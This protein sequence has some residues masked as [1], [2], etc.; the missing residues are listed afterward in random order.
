MQNLSHPLAHYKSLRLSP[1]LARCPSCG[2]LVKRHETKTRYFW[3]ANLFETTLIH[4]QFGYYICPLCPKGEKAFSVIPPLFRTPCQYDR[5]TQALIINLMSVTTNRAAIELIRNWFHLPDLHE[6]TIQRWYVKQATELRE[7]QLHR[8]KLLKDFS[9]QLTIDEMYDDGWCIIRVTDPIQNAEIA[10]KLL[11]RAPTSNDIEVMLRELKEEGFEP[12]IVNTDGSSLYP[13]LIEKIWSAAL[14][15][16]CVFHFIKQILKLLLPAFWVAYQ[17]MP[18]PQKG[19]KGRPANNDKERVKLEKEKKKNRKIVRK[20]RWLLFK[21]P[22]NLSE[23][24]KEQLFAIL[25]LCPELRPLRELICA[26]LAIFG[27]STTLQEAQEKRSAICSSSLFQ[28]KEAFSKVLKKLEDKELFEKL[29]A[30]LHFENAVKTTNH[31]EGK[32]RSYRQRQKVRYRFRCKSSIQALL[33]HLHY[34]KRPSSVSSQNPI[35]VRLRKSGP[36]Q[37]VSP[38]SPA[39]CE[40]EVKQAA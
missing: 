18:L 11:D 23:K 17:T 10:F 13:G 28:S 22:E 36:S 8:Q 31:V 35:R 30:Y 32:N 39:L 7:N 1:S 26:I 19:P 5:F 20:S 15:Q 33:I 3:Q 24:E 25:E 27:S 40:E 21:N 6:T 4:L 37:G 12:L 38:P 2:H 14:H 29:T 34:R 9:R 16:R